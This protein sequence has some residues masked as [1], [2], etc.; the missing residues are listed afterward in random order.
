[1]RG[2]CLEW[3]L[4]V[5]RTVL[6]STLSHTHSSRLVKGMTREDL[7]SLPVGVALPLWDALLRCREAAPSTWSVAAY[8]II[9][10]QYRVLLSLY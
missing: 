6:T 10:V 2:S 5:R 1:M 4:K 3:L 9:G 7:S 8:D